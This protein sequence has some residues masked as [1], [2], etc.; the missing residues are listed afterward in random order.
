MQHFGSEE[1][2]KDQH[3]FDA[4]TPSAVKLVEILTKG[5]DEGCLTAIQLVFE[6]GY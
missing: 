4:R 1:F 3:S 5:V 6:N 2:V